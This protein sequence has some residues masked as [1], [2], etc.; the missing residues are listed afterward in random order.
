MFTDI[1]SEFV[2]KEVEVVTSS[3]KSY[4][5][6]LKQ[7]ASQNA[8]VISPVNEYTVKRYG[9]V[10]IKDTEVVSIREVLPFIDDED[11]CK[12]DSVGMASPAKAYTTAKAYTIAKHTATDIGGDDFGLF[13]DEEK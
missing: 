13:K 6:T 1:F 2:D 8:I 7:Q 4:L 5:G 9:S 3:G 12:D 11:D 10:F